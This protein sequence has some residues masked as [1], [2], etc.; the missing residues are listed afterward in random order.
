V[1]PEVQDPDNYIV[2]VYIPPRA[3]K[4]KIIRDGRVHLWDDPFLYQVYVDGLLK[5]CVPTFETWMIH[6]CCHSL[7]YGGHYGAFCTNAK[8]WQC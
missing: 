8:V 4:K 7:P 2:V 5:R 3:D 6:E 1:V